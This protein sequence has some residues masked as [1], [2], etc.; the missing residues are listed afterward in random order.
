ML[1][2]SN[3]SACFDTRGVRLP[4]LARS[5]TARSDVRSVGGRRERQCGRR[6]HVGISRGPPSREHVR[7]PLNCVAVCVD[8]RPVRS[9]HWHRTGGRFLQT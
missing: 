5:D 8:G 6:R 1:D 4:L 2:R 7:V 3:V 9:Q